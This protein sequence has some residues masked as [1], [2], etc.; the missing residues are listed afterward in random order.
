M[1]TTHGTAPSR[2]GPTHSGPMHRFF[3]AIADMC[4]PPLACANCGKVAKQRHFV[5]TGAVRSVATGEWSGWTAVEVEY[6]CPSCDASTWVED[7]PTYYPM[8]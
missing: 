6:R 1:E 4:S 3:E 2:Q 7:V 5:R 8:G